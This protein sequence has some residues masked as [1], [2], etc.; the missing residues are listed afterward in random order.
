MSSFLAGVMW[1]Q[2]ACRPSTMSSHSRRAAAAVA[3]SRWLKK[4]FT[5]LRS[6]CGSASSGMRRTRRPGF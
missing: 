5:A 1:V 6:E 2:R 3:G 4:H